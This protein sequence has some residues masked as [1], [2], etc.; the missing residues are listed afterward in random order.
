[1]NENGFFASLSQLV[2][3]IIYF[4]ERPAECGFKCDRDFISAAVRRGEPCVHPLRDRTPRRYPK[5]VWCLIDGAIAP[6]PSFITLVREYLKCW[7]YPPG[8]LCLRGEGLEWGY[9]NFM[10]KGSAFILSLQ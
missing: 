5:A 4:A 3:N 2:A 7:V 6:E 8:K 10:K 1:M 9:Q